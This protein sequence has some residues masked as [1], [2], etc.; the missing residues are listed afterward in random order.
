[1]RRTEARGK[2]QSRGTSTNVLDCIQT[3]KPTTSSTLYTLNKMSAWYVRRSHRPGNHAAHRH[4]IHPPRSHKHDPRRSFQYGFFHDPHSLDTVPTVH[5]YAEVL[6]V[7]VDGKV[8]A[9]HTF[10]NRQIV[11]RVIENPQNNIEILQIFMF[12]RDLRNDF[13]TW[14][15]EMMKKQPRLKMWRIL[16][17]IFHVV[18][19]FVVSHFP[20]RYAKFKD[21]EKSW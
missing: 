21:V 18:E 17:R 10:P 15:R 20:W 13:A 6:A 5:E 14:L 19:I 11:Y 12:F 9:S 7:W 4:Q 2:C 1:M 8:Q 16:W 3:N